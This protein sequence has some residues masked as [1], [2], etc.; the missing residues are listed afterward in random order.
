MYLC[1]YGGDREKEDVLTWGGLY[2]H[3]FGYV[4]KSAEVIVARD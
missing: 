3:E 2:N 1:R 4:E